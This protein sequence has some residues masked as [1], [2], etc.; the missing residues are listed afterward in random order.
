[1]KQV[2]N[3]EDSKDLKYCSKVV[4]MQQTKIILY[5]LYGQTEKKMK[6]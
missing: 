1:M 4:K 2:L 3:T 6:S 5:V